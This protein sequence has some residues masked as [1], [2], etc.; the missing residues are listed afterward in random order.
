MG[1][2]EALEKGLQGKDLITTDP[3]SKYKGTTYSYDGKS[4][5]PRENNNLQSQIH[6]QGA[7]AD[8][9]TLA[10]HSIHDLDGKTPNSYVKPADTSGNF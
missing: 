8:Y 7:G 9:S 5:P 10:K 6:A 4:L 1:Q 2:L 3:D